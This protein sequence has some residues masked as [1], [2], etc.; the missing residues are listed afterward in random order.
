MP[1]PS[2][3]VFLLT[4]LLPIL[5]SVGWSER[6]TH[7]LGGRFPPISFPSQGKGLSM[8]LLP[9]RSL[10]VGSKAVLIPSVI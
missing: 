5:P 10:P 4:S 3:R 8:P 7:R 6:N 9:V 2:F 1:L